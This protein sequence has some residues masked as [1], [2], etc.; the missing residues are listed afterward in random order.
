MDNVNLWHLLSAAVSVLDICCVVGLFSLVP[1]QQSGDMWSVSSDCLACQLALGL[2]LLHSILSCFQF[3][4]KRTAACV[5]LCCDLLAVV[6]SSKWLRCV[7]LHIV[8][9]VRQ[10]W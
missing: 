4:C 7:C 6:L 10:C 9:G 3:N 5:H 8:A 1:I 2:A